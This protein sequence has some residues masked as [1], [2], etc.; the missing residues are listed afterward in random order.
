MVL[1]LGKW[2]ELGEYEGSA[3]QSSVSNSKVLVSE[4]SACS[5]HGLVEVSPQVVSAGLSDQTEG[6]VACLS[7]LPVSVGQAFSENWC[8]CF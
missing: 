1:L 7:N 3:A 4:P 6:H 8:G 5:Y 2:T